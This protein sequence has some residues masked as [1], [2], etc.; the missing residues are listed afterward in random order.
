MVERFAARFRKSNSAISPGALVAL[1]S[2]PWPGNL[3]Q[4]ENA[5][6]HAVLVSRG[7][8]LLAEHLPICMPQPAFAP[9]PFPNP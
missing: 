1:Q 8:E 4:L 6:Q 9:R 3:R 2:S 5:V 7:L